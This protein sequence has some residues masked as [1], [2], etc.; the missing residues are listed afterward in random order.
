MFKTEVIQLGWPKVTYGRK[1]ILF[2]SKARALCSTWTAAFT[3]FDCIWGRPRRNMVKHVNYSDTPLL[4]PNAPIRLVGSPGT[5]TC[6]LPKLYSFPGARVAEASGT[7]SSQLLASVTP[8]NLSST[9][10][11][12]LL[13]P[14][15]PFPS[16]PVS[17]RGCSKAPRLSGVPAYPPASPCS[18]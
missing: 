9:P 10:T 1:G 5:W 17:Y 14:S 6:C 3:V 2:P 4:S 12:H 8:E 7:R 13:H 18:P 16:C 11:A 15:H